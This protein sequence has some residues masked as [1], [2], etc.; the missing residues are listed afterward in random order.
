MAEEE[1]GQQ[2]PKKF[3]FLKFC[4]YLLIII[5]IIL[6]I[7]F[8]SNGTKKYIPTMETVICIAKQ[9]ELYISETC[10]HCQTQLNI[11]RFNNYNSLFNIIDCISN[12]EI[13]LNKNI[14]KVPTWIINNK[15][16]GGVQSW[17]E[18]KEL[19]GC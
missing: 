12:T 5:T 9:S 14:I 3:S 8:I 6:I 13:C 15:T 11:L 18:L 16:Y 17:E 7:Y 4:I 19:T 2:Q 1:Q 10:V